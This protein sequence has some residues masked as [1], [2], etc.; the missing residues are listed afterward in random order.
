M[1]TQIEGTKSLHKDMIYGKINVLVTLLARGR[2]ERRL[3]QPTCFEGERFRVN[4][5]ACAEISATL[6]AIHYLL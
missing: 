3:R 4:E 1:Y 6:P 5:Y 2:L